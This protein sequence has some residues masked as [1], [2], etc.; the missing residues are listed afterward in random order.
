MYIRNALNLLIAI[1]FAPLVGSAFSS[2]MYSAD[3][4]ELLVCL[5]QQIRHTSSR[6]TGHRY[7]LYA[8][9]VFFFIAENSSNAHVHYC[10][11]VIFNRR[12]WR[13]EGYRA[14]D[15]FAYGILGSE[16]L[17]LPHC[18]GLSS[19]FCCNETWNHV[20]KANRLNCSHS[21]S[22]VLSPCIEP[23]PHGSGISNVTM[24]VQ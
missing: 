24:A 9:G 21:S 3:C 14:W 13:W 20:G 6:D 19:W 11:S 8:L 2:V 10:G 1:L 15:G 12:P 4:L 17:F 5:L 23:C 7:V 22:S 16:G 18:S